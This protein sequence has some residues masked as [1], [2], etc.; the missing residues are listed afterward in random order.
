MTQPALSHDAS[1]NL[2]SAFA[3]DV[4]AGL[5]HTPQKELPSKY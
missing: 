2:R 5:T 4:R 1:P 3:A